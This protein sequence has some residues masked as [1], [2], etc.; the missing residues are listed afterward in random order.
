[1]IA[2]SE[3]GIIVVPWD[4][5]RLCRAGL[6]HA[7]NM[8][9]NS[10]LIHV[11][12]VAPP[13]SGP[14][15]GVLYTAAEKQKSRELERRFRDQISENSDLNDISF[16]VVYGYVGFEIARFADLYQ[17][18]LIVVPSRKKRTILDIL[19]GGLAKPV[20]SQ[21]RR[22]VLEIQVDESSANLQSQPHI[23]SAT[24]NRVFARRPE[25]AKVG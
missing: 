24:L 19:F 14:D 17:A 2:K 16:H 10:K 3:Q 25:V 22:P 15:N 1:M 7:L 5:S 21:A 11:V 18:E 8:T 4:F 6:D 9:D 12:H 23:F 20:I 13:L